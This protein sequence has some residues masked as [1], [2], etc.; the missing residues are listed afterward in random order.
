MTGAT[1]TLIGIGGAVAAYYCWTQYESGATGLAAA[2]GRD[3][4]TVLGGGGGGGSSAGRA[5]AGAISGNAAGRAA[6]QQQSGGGSS[7][8][9][10]GGGKGSGSG[11]SGSSTA[12][13]TS[14]SNETGASIDYDPETGDYYSSELGLIPTSAGNGSP[15]GTGNDYNPSGGSPDPT[16]PGG[17]DPGGNDPSGEGGGVGDD[18]E[19]GDEG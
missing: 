16:A 15:A 7:G 14:E 11:S 12:Q 13:G 18:P 19:G 17:A 2:V 1:W 4:A 6:Q 5:G 9:G 8:G 3:I 10:S